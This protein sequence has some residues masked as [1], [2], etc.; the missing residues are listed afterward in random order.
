MIGHIRSGEDVAT[1]DFTVPG[2][3]R[4]TSKPERC[5]AVTADGK[6]REDQTSPAPRY[7]ATP[8]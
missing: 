7:A 8:R 1:V 3:P 2:A 6:Y 5:R 4:L